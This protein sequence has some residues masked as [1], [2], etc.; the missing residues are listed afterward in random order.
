[1][2]NKTIVYLKWRVTGR[3]ELFTNLG[4][5]Y[6]RYSEENLGVSRH[7]LNKKDLYK[8]YQNDTVEIVKCTI[9]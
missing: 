4:K 8:G 5:L 6:A 3:F 9:D 7:T 2:R 1:M